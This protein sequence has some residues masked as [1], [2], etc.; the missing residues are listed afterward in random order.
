[1]FTPTPKQLEAIE[2]LARYRRILL[3]GGS[4]S[5]K[6]FINSRSLI[7]RAAK[8]QSRHVCF[9][10]CFNHIKNSLWY[11]T[12]PKVLRDT[13]PGL[14]A[15]FNKSDFFI[16]LPNHSQIWF[17]G[18]D[19]KERTDKIL[20]T[21]YSTIYFNEI[22]QIQYSSIETALTRLSENTQLVKR[23]YFDCNPP[24]KRHWSYKVFFEK[25]NPE[26]NTPL[27]SPDIYAALK[28]NPTDNLDNLPADYID[29]TLNEMT[30][31]KRKRFKDGEYQDDN[32]GAMWNEDIIFP[33]RVAVA[34]AMRRIVVAIDPATTKKRT[35]NST[36][37][38]VCGLGSDSHYYVLQ[39]AS[40]SYT[41]EEWAS[42]AVDLYRRW[43]ADR[44]IGEVNNGGDMVEAVIRNVD[45]TV[46]YKA[47]TATRG[48]M[49]RAEPI[50]AL[51]E[52][53]QVHHVGQFAELEDQQ[54]TWLPESDESPDRIDATVW[55][56]TE[57][58]V[59]KASGG[60]G[61]ISF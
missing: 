16:E 45:R 38:V 7:I 12:F 14:K 51:Y 35:S 61:G 52:K 19:D 23:A 48:K 2:L 30:G 25:N 33:Y 46:S 4:R 36:G 8:E 42:K 50:V 27:L 34:P 3:Y 10:Q 28:M 57:L 55:G 49:L 11:D 58:S 56:L 43:K 29:I 53:G 13:F 1:M 39:D 60:I 5:G 41:P 32:I 37:I 26:T 59:G 22:S 9:R 40:G 54:L 21:E 6:T 15:N 47:V 31:R 44:I 20:G 24:S 17:A 18:L